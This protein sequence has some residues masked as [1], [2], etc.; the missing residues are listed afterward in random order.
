MSEPVIDDHGYFWWSDEPVPPNQF[1]PDSSVAGTI[2]ING[3]GRIDLELHA[4]MPN[5][6]GAW[7]AAASSGKPI[8]PGRG[9]HGI[10]KGSG[11]SVLLSGVTK[12]G[13]HLATAGIS[14]EKFFAEHALLGRGA[15]RSEELPLSFRSLVIELGG[16]E[17][18]LILRSIESE[19]TQTTL[20]A[21]YEAP[22]DVTYPLEEGTLV[23]RYDI[24]GPYLGKGRTRHLE[25][26]ESASI[27]YVPKVHISLEEAKQEYGLLAEL[28]IVL[29]GSSYRLDWPVLTDGGN[30]NRYQFVFMRHSSTAKPPELHECWTTFPGI[31]ES[32]GEIAARWRKK[33]EEFGPGI[34]LYLGTQRETGLYVENR[35]VNLVWGV[36]ALHRKMFPPGQVPTALQEK[37]ARILGQIEQQ[38]D[39]KWLERQLEYAAEPRLEARIFETFSR[40]PL[41][42]EE[43]PLRSFSTACA[44]QRNRISHFGGQ[45]ASEDYRKFVI[46][47]AR[48]SDALTYLYHV[49][50]LQ[51]IGINPEIIRSFVYRGFRSY[52]IKSA[53]AEAGLLPR[54]ALAD[55]DEGAGVAGGAPLGGAG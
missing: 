8:P 43:E 27:E 16:F 15:L 21:R 5:E 23:L 52:P 45:D 53:F 2:R 33:R 28:F 4:V 42:L 13:A 17:E 22:E 18:W 41:G 9:I 14:Y 35:F 26:I 49:L 31:K 10:L 47:L 7:G 19:R 37:I 20:T 36:E 12:S 24:S 44:M 3:D 34:A 55:Q 51:E 38:K 50:L 30:D 48:K 25:L 6:H 39:R 32:F 1:A 54:S 11:R 46:D 29:T 40:L